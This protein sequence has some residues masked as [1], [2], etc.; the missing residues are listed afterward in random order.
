MASGEL[1]PKVDRKALRMLVVGA[2][3]WAP[4]WYRASGTSSPEE[5]ADL[6]VR[7]LVRGVGLR[8]RKRA[9]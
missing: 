2:M 7:M 9:T 8:P 4:E 1:D 5:I 6:L 3:N